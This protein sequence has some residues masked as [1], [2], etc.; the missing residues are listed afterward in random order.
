ML[1][2]TWDRAEEQPIDWIQAAVQLQK[3]LV[4][5]SRWLA[6]PLHPGLDGWSYA[7]RPVGWDRKLAGWTVRPHFAQ[8]LFV[9]HQ[10]V[11]VMDMQVVAML[12]SIGARPPLPTSPAD[13]AGP[14][15]T[16][17]SQPKRSSHSAPSQLQPV[18]RLQDDS[19]SAHAITYE[20]DRI[21]CTTCGRSQAATHNWP[22]FRAST[23]R[24]LFT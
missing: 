8:P 19:Q 11:L 17:P 18:P 13:E 21:L 2:Y 3:N 23:C 5:L 14:P 15:T 24:P 20:G 16:P 12:N 9:D 10:T 4:A 6:V 7:L 1:P 22:R